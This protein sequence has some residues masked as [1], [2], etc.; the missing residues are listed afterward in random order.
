MEESIGERGQVGLEEA[1]LHEIK[2]PV[3]GLK[4][5]EIYHVVKELIA[6]VLY[7]HQQI[8]ETLQQLEDEFCRTEEAGILDE[9]V[10]MTASNACSNRQERHRRREDKLGKRRRKNLM[11]GISCLLSSFRI[12]LDEVP[13]LHCIMLVLGSTLT[14]PQYAY[15][16]VFS[17]QKIDLGS[18]RDET[19]SKVAGYV[20]KQAI[21]SLI[22][23]GEGGSRSG[24]MKLYLLVRAP[25]DVKIPMHFLPKRNF[26]CHKKTKLL[27]LHC[28]CKNQK[29]VSAEVPDAASC[30]LIWF[31]CR[32][33]VKG[34]S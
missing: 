21:R 11:T 26:K 8:P 34:L 19:Q 16:I 15:D 5:S 10:P 23:G 14:R 1:N 30:D 17:H 29:Q 32:H 28:R 13:I 31:Q 4:K 9:P 27:R 25:A 6:H 18:S 22:S 3:E 12:I 2:V 24:P 33:A 7:I 20:S